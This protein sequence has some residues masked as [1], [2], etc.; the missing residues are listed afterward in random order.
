MT[1]Q[2][3][4]YYAKAIAAGVYGGLIYLMSVIAPSASHLGDIT[5]LQ[6]IGFAASV[7]GSSGIVAVIT[8]G[9]KPLKEIPANTDGSY[10]VTS[11]PAQAPAD[12]KSAS[13]VA[14][15]IV[16]PASDPVTP[17]PAP[18]TPPAK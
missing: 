18:A 4:S 13:Y 15:R 6:W 11:V 17:D 1:M 16:Q 5:L 8:N 7:L 2:L 10:T 14:P 3:L 9:P 12:L